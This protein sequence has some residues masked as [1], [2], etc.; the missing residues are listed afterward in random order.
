[1]ERVLGLPGG[2]HKNF[3]ISGRT[4]PS[5]TSEGALPVR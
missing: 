3:I 4:F 2:T 5:A 1:V